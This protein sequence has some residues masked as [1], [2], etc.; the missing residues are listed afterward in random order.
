LP[1]PAGEER[2]VPG[3]A[4]AD[5]NPRR[6]EDGEQRGNAGAQALPVR[7]EQLA[8]SGVCCAGVGCVLVDAAGGERIDGAARG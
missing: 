1:E 8:G 2:Q 4:A 6:A 5:D 3:G 7:D